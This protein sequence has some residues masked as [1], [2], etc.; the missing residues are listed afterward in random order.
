MKKRSLSTIILCAIPLSALALVFYCLE[1]YNEAVHNESS[2]F[3]CGYSVIAFIIS[4]LIWHRTKKTNRGATVTWIISAVVL[5]L[6]FYVGSK[7]PFCVVCDRVTAE[8]LGFL[9]HWIQPEGTIP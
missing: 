6:V 7:I 3:V 1:T 8:D 5:M 4:T 9:I 2:F